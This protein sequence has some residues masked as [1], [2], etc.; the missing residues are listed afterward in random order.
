MVVLSR[1]R[2]GVFS[3]F[4]NSIPAGKST[5]SILLET[6]PTPHYGPEPVS[7]DIQRD[8]P[9]LVPGRDI[10]TSSSGRFE[11]VNYRPD[12]GLEEGYKQ[13]EYSRDRR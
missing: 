5:R 8:P 10:N 4:R 13:V 7:L 3:P 1:E 9:P 12:R 11:R 6:F 2:T